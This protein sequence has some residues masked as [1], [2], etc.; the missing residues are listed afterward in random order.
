MTVETLVTNAAEHVRGEREAIEAKREAYER[1]ARRIGA[2]DAEPVRGAS[3]APTGATVAVGP[4]DSAG[5]RAVREA[6]AETVRPAVAGEREALVETLG[7][8]LRE[9]IARAVAPAG[10]DVRFTPELKRAVR[11]ATRARRLELRALSTLLDREA[12]SLERAAER[13]DDVVAWIADR[14]GS[15][16]LELDF[17]ALRER[18]EDLERHR[19][20]CRALVRDRQRFL[21]RTT[22]VGAQVGLR[23]RTAVPGIY[24]GAG[25]EADHPVLATAVRVERVCRRCQRAVRDHLTRRV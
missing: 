18:H 6:F 21:G 3:G 2:I 19:D 9:E 23:H 22:S 1:F 7:A 17:E 15:S 16:L 25:F 24:A 8:E 13:L 10:V 14:N 5:C 11:A 12:A 4:A 20:R